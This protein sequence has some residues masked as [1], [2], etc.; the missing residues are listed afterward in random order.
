MRGG[1][2]YACEYE[3]YDMTLLLYFT[4]EQRQSMCYIYGFPS[5]VDS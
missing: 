2:S 4:R 3:P 5:Y 1:G